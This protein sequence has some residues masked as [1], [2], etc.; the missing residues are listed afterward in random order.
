M[1]YVRPRRN[2]TGGR[3]TRSE[4]SVGALVNVHHRSHRKGEKGVE[5]R[6][7]GRAKEKNSDD[8]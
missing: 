8:L 3:A 5:G 7:E 1:V 2:A 4:E 6:L